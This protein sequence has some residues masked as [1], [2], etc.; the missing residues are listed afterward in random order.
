VSAQRGDDLISCVS[1]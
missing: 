1:N